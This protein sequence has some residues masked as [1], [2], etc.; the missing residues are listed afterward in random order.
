MA[1]TS[2]QALYSITTPALRSTVHLHRF[3]QTPPHPGQSTEA[4]A[5]AAR[6]AWFTVAATRDITLIFFVG[7][8]AATGKLPL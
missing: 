8:A 6:Q 2:V 1:S 3:V 5:F 4:D 7:M